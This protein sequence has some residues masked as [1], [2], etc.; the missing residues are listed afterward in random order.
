MGE[1]FDRRQLDRR[2]HQLRLDLRDS[3][4]TPHHDVSRDP[5]IWRI[6]AQRQSARFVDPKPKLRSVQT[7]RASRLAYG[8]IRISRS[9]VNRSKKLSSVA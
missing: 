4:K 9:V 5:M 3:T 2:P 7:A 1:C 8:T 6:I